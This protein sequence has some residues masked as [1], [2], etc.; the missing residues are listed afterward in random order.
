MKT[1]TII[2][3]TVV[4]LALIGGAILLSKNPGNGNTASVQNNV[5]VSQGKQIVEIN[6]RGGYSPKNNTATAG[7]PTLLRLKTN[8]TFDCSSA[9][10]IP[11]LGISQNLPSTGTTDID[12]GIPKKGK[13]L[14]SCIMGMYRFE[15]NFN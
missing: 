13:L 1:S 6:A 9:V 10:R 12:L 7:M 2:G 5:F 4:A 3:A 15:I 14:G 8:G 11:N